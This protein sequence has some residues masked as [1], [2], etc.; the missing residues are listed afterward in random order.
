[1]VMGLS[2]RV[3][4]HTLC[5]HPHHPTPIGSYLPHQ[6]QGFF[7]GVRIKFIQGVVSTNE[8]YP[9]AVA[10]SAFDFFPLQIFTI[11]KT[12]M[13]IYWVIATEF[14]VAFCMVFHFVIFPTK[15]TGMY[16][17]YFGLHQCSLLLKWDNPVITS[18]GDYHGVRNI[19]PIYFQAP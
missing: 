14:L 1:M 12:H 13:V 7:S 18:I 16:F 3:K 8:S 19:N 2:A 6:I 9:L 17:H 4:M 5:R 10:V 11:P 15:F